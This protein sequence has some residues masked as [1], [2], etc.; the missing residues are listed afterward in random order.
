[1]TDNIKVEGSKSGKAVNV[2]TDEV[3]NVH[4]PVYKMAIGADGEAVLVGDDNPLHVTS[5]VADRINH[6]ELKYL[7]TD[8]LKELK[9]MN[10]YNAEAQD[11]QLTDEDIIL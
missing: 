10:L 11:E 1:M 4:Y 6:D 3:S 7:L 9:I 5:S 2:A 8:I